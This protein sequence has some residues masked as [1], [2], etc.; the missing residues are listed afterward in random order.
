MSIFAPHLLILGTVP[1]LV[2]GLSILSLSL[3]QWE[4]VIQLANQRTLPPASQWL[5][6]G[7]EQH[8]ARPIRVLPGTLAKA[9]RNALFSDPTIC[10][11]DTS[12]KYKS[13][14][15][16]PHWEESQ[17]EEKTAKTWWKSKTES[18][19][20]SLN[21]WIHPCLKSPHC[22]FTCMHPQNSL[23]LSMLF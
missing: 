18:L 21:S 19:Q 7:C 16:K 9:K 10:K 14:L 4:L 8:C 15:G 13:H 5:V 6:Q 1:C 20:Y 11:N 22:S 12:P 3:P 17:L 23:Y 2:E